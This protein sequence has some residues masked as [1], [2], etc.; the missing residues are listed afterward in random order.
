[1]LQSKVKGFQ[2][3]DLGCRVFQGSAGVHLNLA[4][5]G[6]QGFGCYM[7]GC[8]IRTSGGSRG[9][10]PKQSQSQKRKP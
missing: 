7:S 2:F 4:A 9:P 6:L 1:M 10:L 5:T 8:Y 3:R